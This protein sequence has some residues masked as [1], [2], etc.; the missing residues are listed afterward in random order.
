MSA[1]DMR[2]YVKSVTDGCT[3]LTVCDFDWDALA[4][5]PT[6]PTRRLIRLVADTRT[7]Q[8]SMPTVTRIV[9]LQ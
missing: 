1:R 7:D 6:V 2:D 9:D 3:F 5:Y 8:G 4:S